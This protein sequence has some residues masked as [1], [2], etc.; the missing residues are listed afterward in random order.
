VELSQ[1]ILSGIKAYQLLAIVWFAFAFVVIMSADTFGGWNI[2]NVVLLIVLCTNGVIEAKR[3]NKLKQKY[4]RIIE[5]H[6]KLTE[7]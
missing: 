6:K 5:I 4:S 3:H 2:K 1:D 7:T